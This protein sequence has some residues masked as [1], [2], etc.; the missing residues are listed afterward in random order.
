MKGRLFTFGCSFTR[1]NWPTW[2]DILGK[3]YLFFHNWGYPGVGNRAIVE[4]VAEAHTVHDINKDDTVIIQWS[5]HLRHDY[6][7]PDLINDADGMWKT[8]GNIFSAW[9][10]DVFD[11]KWVETFWNKKAYYLHTLNSILLAK[12]FLE[13]TGCNWYMTSMADLKNIQNLDYQ[14]RESDRSHVTYDVFKNNPDLIPYKEKIWDIDE[15]RWLPE[16]LKEKNT[17]PELDWWFKDDNPKKEKREFVLKDGKF[18]EP[19]LTY[20]QYYNYLNKNKIYDRLGISDS[21]H[22]D[23]IKDI[24]FYEDRVSTSKT[25]GEFLDRVSS[26]FWA[27]TVRTLGR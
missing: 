12:Q 6:A 15:D 14:A 27:M 10:E 20:Q 5:S 19:H 17:T 24:E 18:R 2:A 11:K 16:L 13:S 25:Y 22:A 3:E 21:N 4:R 23:T 26:T 1:Y 9:N 8:K 7:R